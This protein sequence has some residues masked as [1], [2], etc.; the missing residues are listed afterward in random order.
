MGFGIGDALR[1]AREE[2]GRAI[3]DVA[4]ATRVRA[5]YLRALESEE[6]GVLG[7]DVY[8]RGFLAA[9]AKELGM[10]PAPLLESFRRHAKGPEPSASQLVTV[11]AAIAPRDSPPWIVWSLAALVVISV[12]VWVAGSIGGRNPEPSPRVEAPPAPS[13]ETPSPTDNPTAERTPTVA[14]TPDEVR[15]FIAFQDRVWISPVVDGL[16][17][18]AETVE[19]GETRE[20]V[21]SDQVEIR[22]GNLGGVDIELNGQLLESLG[23]TG[24]VRTILFGRTGIIDDDVEDD[25]VEQQPSPSPSPSPS[26]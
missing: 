13:S 11:P 6:F 15:V 12:I 21:G 18:G 3:E 7:G 26:A 4:R 14:P 5:D 16:P 19:A 20:F 25:A 22:F 10:D 24:Q 2:Q 8:A 1:G 17:I 9:Y 23:R